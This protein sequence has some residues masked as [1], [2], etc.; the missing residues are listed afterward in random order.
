MGEIA[1]VIMLIVGGLMLGASALD[2]AKEVN[3]FAMG[4]MD[5]QTDDDL[6]EAAGHFAQAVIKGGVTLISAILLK[7]MPDTFK[8]GKPFKPNSAPTTLASC[9]TNPPLCR[10]RAWVRAW[11]IPRNSAT[12]LSRARAP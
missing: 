9:F 1:D 4:A 5:A 6:T 10:T 2:V 8:E 7:K 12:L 11:A 3:A